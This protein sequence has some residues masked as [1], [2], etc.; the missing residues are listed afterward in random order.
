MQLHCNTSRVL[1]SDHRQDVKNN[2]ITIIDDDDEDI[3][4]PSIPML[5]T[6]TGSKLNKKQTT[7][8]ID[9]NNSPV[10]QRKFI[11][12]TIDQICKYLDTKL[13]SNCTINVAHNLSG[14]IFLVAAK[15]DLKCIIE[16][17][18]SDLKKW[19][20]LNPLTENASMVRD[21]NV[22]STINELDLFMKNIHKCNS[23]C[24]INILTQFSNNIHSVIEVVK[25]MCGNES[26]NIDDFCVML[27]ELNDLA[28][29]ALNDL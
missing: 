4:G 29:L 14:S 24:V 23:I 17:M 10:C 20:K 21:F 18:H 15:N 12:F 27:T 22:T 13:R 3:A 25:K 6:S 28:T 8:A 11:S 5:P 26:L 16:C 2:P 19:E 9:L 1:C 7:N